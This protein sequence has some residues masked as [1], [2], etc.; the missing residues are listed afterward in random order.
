MSTTTIVILVVVA[1]VVLALVAFLVS[2]ANA[3]HREQR[4]VEAERLRVEARERDEPIAAT[5]NHVENLRE[6]ADVARAEADRAEHRVVE[7]EQALAQEEAVQ[8]DR[9]READRIDPGAS[10][11]R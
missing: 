10:H 4:R 3:K 7:A 8:E 2:R 9:L 5:R 11:R 1:V 6:E